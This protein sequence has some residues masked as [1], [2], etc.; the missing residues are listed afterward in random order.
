MAT[1]GKIIISI[2]HSG[3][4]RLSKEEGEGRVERYDTD[5]NMFVKNCAVCQKCRD[6][7]MFVK[8]CAVCQKCRYAKN[9]SSAPLHS[10]VHYMG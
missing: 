9:Y 5:D 2:S 3:P 1:I 6:D 7:N 4:S 8:N 10:F